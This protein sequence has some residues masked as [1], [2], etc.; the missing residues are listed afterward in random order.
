MKPVPWAFCFTTVW[1]AALHAFLRLFTNN[2]P[3]DGTFTMPNWVVPASIFSALAVAGLV[4]GAGSLARAA[5]V[6]LRERRRER[7][8]EHVKALAEWV[9]DFSKTYTRWQSALSVRPRFDA[10]PLPGSWV[11]DETS[12]GWFSVR[13]DGQ[14]GGKPFETSDPELARMVRDRWAR[15]FWG[16]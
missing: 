5:V 11:V 14:D 13:R 4:M 8:R 2:A 1:F 10:A 16:T 6:A 15:E 12:E 9:D 7:A 3:W